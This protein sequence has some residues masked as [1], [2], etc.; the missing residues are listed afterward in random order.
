MAGLVSFTFPHG[1]GYGEYAWI[2]NYTIHDN[3]GDPYR[4]EVDSKNKSLKIFMLPCKAPC[5]ET[6]IKSEK[7]LKRYDYSKIWIGVDTEVPQWSGNTILF[8]ERSTGK[9]IW[10]GNHGIEELH[11]PKGEEI[12]VLFSPVGNN[13]VPYTYAVGKKNIYL[14]LEGAY[15]PL[16]A[17][18]VRSIFNYFSDVYDN[19]YANKSVYKQMEPFTELASRDCPW[20]GS[21]KL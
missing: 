3:M 18:D 17:I 19:Y 20:D 4:V 8:Q 9:L 21:C 10:I 12:L 15:A 6:Q 2:V 14:L 11:L 5:A 16:E 7:F 1:V 13:D